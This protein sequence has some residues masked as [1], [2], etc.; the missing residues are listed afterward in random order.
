M[1]HN[2]CEAFVLQTQ[3]SSKAK[4]TFLKTKTIFFK[5]NVCVANTLKFLK[6]KK[7]TVLKAKKK[8]L[9]TNV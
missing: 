1:R 9:K 2:P 8:F 6:A 4:I 5:V 7:S 3:Y